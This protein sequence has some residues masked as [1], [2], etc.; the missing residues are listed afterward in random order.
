[1]LASRSKRRMKA[2]RLNSYG[3]DMS[4]EAGGYSTQNTEYLLSKW[5]TSDEQTGGAV[6]VAGRRRRYWRLR[7]SDDE[8]D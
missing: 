1:M 3:R 4:G 5:E 7:R 2:P 6:E 8:R